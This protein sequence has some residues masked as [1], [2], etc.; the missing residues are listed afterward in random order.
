MIIGLI[1]VFLLGGFLGVLNFAFEAELDREEIY[2]EESED[3]KV[4]RILYE[5]ANRAP[6]YPDFS[7]AEQVPDGIWDCNDSSYGGDQFWT[8]SGPN[9]IFACGPLGETYGEVCISVTENSNGVD[10]ECVLD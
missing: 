5:E 8:A 9:A 3:L 1:I 10:D 6:R 4:Q 2:L 7:Q